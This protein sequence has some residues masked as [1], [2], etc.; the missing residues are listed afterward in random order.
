MRISPQDDPK[1]KETFEIYRLW[2]PVAIGLWHAGLRLVVAA[3]GI[4]LD[5]GDLVAHQ[6]EG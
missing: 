4:P 2:Q 6:A 1:L 5:R 3:T